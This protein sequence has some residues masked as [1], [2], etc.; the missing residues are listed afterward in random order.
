MFTKR[1]F[2]VLFLA[3]ISGLSFGSPFHSPKT[4]SKMAAEYKGQKE[5]FASLA[6]DSRTLP[7][8]TLECS[9]GGSET[10]GNLGTNL[11]A[12][13]DRT[14]TGDN[15]VQWSATDSRNDQALT[16]KAITLRSGV[17]KNAVA[18]G[19]GIGVLNFNYKR[20]FTGNSTLKVFVNGVEKQS[21]AV[22]S[23]TPA[24]ATIL[25]N[26][27]GNVN[28]EFRN[29]G[30]RIVID[31]V[32]WDCYGTGSTSPQ[33][34]LADSDNNEVECGTFALNFGAN[35]VNLSQ[36]KLFTIKNTGTA[37]LAINS[38][39]L[40]GANAADFSVIAPVG[41]FTVAAQDSTLV[42][43][44]FANTGVGTKNATL[45]INRTGVAEQCTVGLLGTGLLECVAPV[46]T[47]AVAVAD[48]NPL[49][50]NVAVSNVAAGGYFAVLA[51]TNTLSETPASG[52]AYEVGAAFGGGTVV[53]NGTGANFPVSVLNYGSNPFLHI[54]PYNSGDCTNGPI[55][56]SDKI[57]TFAVPCTAGYET[58]S[59]LESTTSNSYLTRTW[60]GDYASWQATDARTDQALAGKAIALRSGT[61]KNTTPVAG[62]G[63]LTFS[64]KRVFTGNSTLKVFVNGDQY[65]TDIAVSADTPQVFSQSIQ[66]SADAVI[67]I[68]NAEGRVIID[69]LAWTCYAAPSTP[70]IQLADNNG[71]QRA[72]GNFTL[73]FGN[74]AVGVN[75]ERTFNITNVGGQN[76][77]ISSIVSNNPAFTITSAIPSVILPSESAEVTVQLNSTGLAVGDLAASISIASNDVS[78]SLNLKASVAV[79]CTAPVAGTVAVSNET[80]FSADVVVSGAAA[81]GYIAVVSTDP[82]LGSPSAELFPYSPG[83]SIDNGTVVYS[84]TNPSFNISSFLDPS[85]TYYLNVFAYNSSEDCAGPA[86]AAAAT[87][88]FTT[89]QTLCGGSETFSN[90]GAAQSNY[91]T[92]SWT[93]DNLVSWTAT[94]SRTD[95]TLTGKAITLRTGTLTNVNFPAT[96]GMTNLSFNYKRVFTGNSTLKVFVNDV[97]YGGDIT[98]SADTPAVFTASMDITDD[99][100]IRIENSGNRVVI[101]DLVWTCNPS[102]AKPALKGKA[103]AASEVVGEVKLYPNPNKGQ[104]QIQFGNSEAN[105]DVVV[106]DM[107][108]KKVFGK[109]VADSEM[110]DLGNVQRGIYLVS[111]TSGSTVSNKKI[112]VE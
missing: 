68:V 53:Y 46:G 91:I 3:G 13:V 2:Q 32:S 38:L 105:A 42:L 63:T 82:L 17:L 80:Y 59:N 97:Q 86:F 95:Q 48:I 83:S 96:A 12:Y 20:V 72:C 56:A 85:T 41:S 28:L 67:E 88:T 24:S 23:E 102:A 47:P 101:D 34:E 43:V 73:D 45:T 26:V 7:F 66:L 103:V 49:F 77:L 87:S 15:G 8:G 62:I 16:G 9:G 4:V 37:P 27:E 51:G 40:S 92:R 18:V 5:W 100:T 104:F 69:N 6:P 109:K 50:A 65:G 64:Y 39:A 44:R 71:A 14:W 61:L 11:T 74:I 110:I 89:V 106:Y 84:G 55:Y 21:I 78:C 52:T 54:F 30:N 108:G 1:F 60:T 58:F 90:I 10:F 70:K 22:T 112:V 19:G 111:I 93:G 76:L 35:A 81:T 33:L 31:D 94:D 25:I 29:S 99:V 57:E 98:V 79:P 36:D 107:T 75:R